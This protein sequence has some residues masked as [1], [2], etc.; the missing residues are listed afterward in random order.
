MREG[1]RIMIT[2]LLAAALTMSGCGGGETPAAGGSTGD[3]AV[4]VVETEK[5]AGPRVMLSLNGKTLTGSTEQLLA[6]GFASVSVTRSADGDE[7]A[8][9]A[10]LNFSLEKPMGEEGVM[11]VTGSLTMAKDASVLFD[12]PVEEEEEWTEEDDASPE[13]E[14]AEEGQETTEEPPETPEELPEEDFFAEEEEEEEEPDHQ[15]LSAEEAAELLTTIMGNSLSATE[16]GATLKTENTGSL[17]WQYGAAKAVSGKDD[18]SVLN[19]SASCE[20]EGVLLYLNAGVMVKG[21]EDAAEQ[22]TKT[23]EG[24]GA[25][26]K[27]LAFT[28]VQGEI[29][30]GKD[31]LQIPFAGKTLAVPGTDYLRVSGAELKFAASTHYLDASYEGMVLTEGKEAGF[32]ASLKNKNAMTEEELAAMDGSEG[33]TLEGK[34]LRWTVVTTEAENGGR[35]LLAR[36]EAEGQP[37]FFSME[38]MGFGEHAAETCDNVI[39]NAKGWLA[40]L[41]IQ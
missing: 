8:S 30:G 29:L 25:W 28:N 16:A 36:T 14:A 26:M 23:E 10:S 1:K 12:I 33:E 13:E 19:F 4:V 5:D 37:L 41:T 35:M 3:D 20:A 9:S 34:G 40:A 11:T 18:Y 24:L 7:E 2:L 38:V 39:Q 27:S 6:G 22:L 32:Y 17:T 15:I 21:A 31:R